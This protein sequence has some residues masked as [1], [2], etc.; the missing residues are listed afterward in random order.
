M[1]SNIMT[2]NCEVVPLFFEARTLFVFIKVTLESE[3]LA[4]SSTNERF[5]GRMC[6]DV[7][8]QIGFICKRF[9]TLWTRERFFACV[10]SGKE[11]KVQVVD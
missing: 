3:S 4:T 5:C 6:L 9:V 10:C 2:F 1:P 8:P 7:C 11:K